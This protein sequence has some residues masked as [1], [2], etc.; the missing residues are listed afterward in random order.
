MLEYKEKC[1]YTRA[2]RYKDGHGN[3]EY[4]GYHWCD[5]SDNTCDHY[6]TGS[7]CESWEDLKK[8]E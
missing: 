2:L 5:L 3:I 6:T 4:S 7:E 1:P 8:E